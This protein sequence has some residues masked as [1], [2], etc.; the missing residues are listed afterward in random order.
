M[1]I[2]R[3]SHQANHAPGDR[4]GRN[5]LQAVHLHKPLRRM[6]ISSTKG[7]MMGFLRVM[8]E[9]GAEIACGYG[10]VNWWPDTWVCKDCHP[11][12]SPPEEFDWSPPEK[13]D[14]AG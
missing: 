11:D 13:K 2:V 1:D 14:K 3:F 8:A 6:V 4:L 10:H 7:R 5:N 12:W 9:V